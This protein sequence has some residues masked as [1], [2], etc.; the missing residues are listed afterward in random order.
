MNG[1]FPF[2]DL[3]F[4]IR[5]DVIDIATINDSSFLLNLRLVNKKWN[6]LIQSVLQHRS[7][8]IQRKRLDF[9]L[10]KQMPTLPTTSV[11]LKGLA[12]LVKDDDDYYDSDQDSPFSWRNNPEYNILREFIER[13]D[14]GTDKNAYFLHGT[15]GNG[16]TYLMNC[17]SKTYQEQY[18]TVYVHGKSYTVKPNKLRLLNAFKEALSNTP[19]LLIIDDADK[20]VFE[21]R[22]N[23]VDEWY[24]QKGKFQDL[25]ESV[26]NVT[27]LKIILTSNECTLYK[28][29]F[30]KFL[31]NIQHIPYIAQKERLY[32]LRKFTADLNFDPEI[33]AASLV[34]SLNGHVVKAVHCVCRRA[35][36]LAI[37]K[38]AST[39][40]REDF[41]KAIQYVVFR[42][43]VRP[44][45]IRP[46]LNVSALQNPLVQRNYQMCTKVDST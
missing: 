8:L 34:R 39:I 21:Y 29:E 26:R 42:Q 15:S 16:T 44:F 22:S 43:G 1:G 45:V 12:T 19:C 27:G 40:T 28:T 17:I 9:G 3:P 38:G 6:V 31:Y 13:R 35:A 2:D 33:R 23:Y 7:W 14:L 4:L 5:R 24:E 25:M 41:S 10:L 11:T 36:S 20:L 30:N 46:C 18:H 32:I 37:L